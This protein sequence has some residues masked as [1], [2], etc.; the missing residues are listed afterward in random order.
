VPSGRPRELS[1]MDFF[2]SSENVGYTELVFYER[3]GLTFE[4]LKGLRGKGVQEAP[5]R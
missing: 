4:R 3:L 5:K 1:V 2:P